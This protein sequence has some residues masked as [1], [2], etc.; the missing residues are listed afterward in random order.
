MTH[1]A[2]PPRPP[3]LLLPSPARREDGA[4]STLESSPWK[5]LYRPCSAGPAPAATWLVCKN[6]T[7]A[8]EHL[9]VHESFSNRASGAFDFSTED[10]GCWLKPGL[11]FKEEGTTQLRTFINMRC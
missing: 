3:P 1:L 8:P 2:F 5:P 9:P 4:G 11:Y 6:V 7:S 10:A